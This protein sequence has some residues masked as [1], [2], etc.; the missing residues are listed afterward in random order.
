MFKHMKQNFGLIWQR[1][2][3][4]FSHKVVAYDAVRIEYYELFIIK[5]ANSL[6]D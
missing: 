4:Y 6:K 3:T 2:R 1:R 5:V